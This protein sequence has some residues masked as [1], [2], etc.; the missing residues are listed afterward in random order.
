[1]K[2]QF[3]K[4]YQFKVVLIG[5]DPPIWRR[6][7]V[8]ASYT[9][10]DLHV[11]IQD[12]MGWW[13]YHLHEFEV[14]NP[15][16]GDRDRI[17]I[18]SDEFT[19]ELEWLAGWEIPISAYFSPENPNA[20]YTYDFGD[21]W[22]HSVTLERILPRDP[23]V[24][25]PRCLSG[26]RACPPED[27]GGVYGYADFLEAIQDP[28]HEEHHP[29]LEWVGGSFDPEHFHPE[30]VEFDDP[31]K[32]WRIA[33]GGREDAISYAEQVLEADQGAAHRF[34]NWVQQDNGDHAAQAEALPLRRDMVTVLTY[35]RD[36]RVTGTQSTGNFPLKVVREVTAQFVDPPQLETTI[37]DR[38]YRLRS[39]DDVWPL[40]FLHTLASVG[41][42]LEGGPARRWRLAPV[43]EKF[44]AAHPLVQVWILLAVWWKQVNWLIAYPFEGMGESLP[45]RFEEITLDHLL[46]SPVDT[47]IPFEP[48]ADRLIENTGLTWTSRDTTY[49]RMFLHAAVQR[50]VIEVMADFEVVEPEY[51]D[52]PLGEGTISELVAFQITPFGKRLLESLK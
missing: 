50:M 33:F 38:T 1:M 45:P 11:A 2:A 47:R 32:R 48:F 15:A 18:P 4:I 7:Q 21:D 17:G 10:W 23:D 19:P 37:G 39:E 22:H 43:G 28:Q 13:D 51:Q 31:D 52:K 20:L 30:E 3:S 34:V 6:I 5:V 9:F 40:S 36:Q 44:L 29:M 25:Y 24:D 16:T 41:G 27:C 14:I 35:V 8:P 49:H 12:A 26:E 46:S 42:L